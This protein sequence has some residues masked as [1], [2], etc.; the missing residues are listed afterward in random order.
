M[1]VAEASLDE[2]S[3]RLSLAEGRRLV[4]TRDDLFVCGPL[5]EEIWELTREQ[6]LT[7][8]S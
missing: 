7:A 5:K 8:N 3:R 1:R 4:E 2:A 6:W